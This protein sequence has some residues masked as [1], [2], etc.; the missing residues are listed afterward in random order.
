[1]SSVTGHSVGLAANLAAAGDA[2]QRDVVEGRLHVV[3]PHRL[4]HCIARRAIREQHVE[5]VVRRVAV[6]GNHGEPEAELVGDRSEQ[7]GVCLGDEATLREDDISLL[8]LAVEHRGEHFA[9][10]ERRTDVLP[11]VLVDFAQHER[12]AVRTLVVEDVRPGDVVLLVEDERAAFAADEV[13]GLVEAERGEA[14]EASERPTAVRA[15]QPVRVVFD[16]GD[17]APVDRGLDAG[18][19]APDARVVDGNDRADGVVFAEQL[20]EVNGVEPERVGL[21]VAE[22]DL[23]SFTRERQGRGREGE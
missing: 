2:V 23:R 21:D 15:E 17:V 12:A 20:R 11:R 16:D 14:P 7:C 8:E 3:L 9:Q 13:L 5:H 18:D 6:V 19:V 4:Q 10:T 1:M 22:K